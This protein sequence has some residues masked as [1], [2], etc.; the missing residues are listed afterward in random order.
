MVLLPAMLLVTVQTVTCQ[1]NDT[2]ITG[3]WLGKLAVGAVQ[4]RIVFNVSVNEEG[5]L[6]ATMDSP[7]QGAKD[8]P[9]GKV[10]VRNDSLRIEAPLVMGYYTGKIIYETAIDGTWYQSN[11]NFEL[12][13][14]KQMT[15]FVLNRPQEPKP[16]FP[17]IEE[18]V[19]FRNEKDGFELAGTL[20]IPDKDK[21]YP[22][23]ILISGSGSQNRDE[24]I[25]GH[26]PFKVI[27]DHLTRNGVAVLRYDDR[28]VG[29]S[30]GSPVGTTS[31]DFSRDARAAIDYILLNDNIDG[32]R[33]GIIGHSEGG[34]IAQILASEFDDIAFIISLAGPGVDGRTILLD[35]AEYISRLS[36]IHDT[37]INQ[38]IELNSLIFDIMAMEEDPSAGLTKIE[39][40]IR[41]NMKDKGRP[42]DA[43]EIVS[44]LGLQI[45]AASYQWIRYFILFDPAEY[46]PAI[47][48]P[49]LALNGDKD[50]QVMAGTNIAAIL[51]ILKKSGNSNAKGLIMKDLNHLFQ[52]C[53]TG[54]A[55]EYGDIE[56]TI[57]PEV[58]GIIT[59]WINSI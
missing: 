45:N 8:V 52:R 33:I 9:M 59:D 36:N 57:S 16:P 11:M 44:N 32:S 50:C 38:N 2:G 35:Q 51:E 20:T 18:E 48:C 30:G 3:I 46:L 15:A 17:Y 10:T 25:F 29:K 40:M 42:K 4:L 6:T 28:G 7:D 49:V 41:Q 14:E 21:V 5:A 24:E 31:Y 58:L 39:E 19:S 22:A 54:L 56:E 13:L 53:E 1:V 23:V 47:K 43:D 55:N 12:D 27:A 34:A 26:K 37:V